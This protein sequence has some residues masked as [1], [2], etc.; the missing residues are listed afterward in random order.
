VNLLFQTSSE[1]S[2][3][4][5]LLA[6][7][8]IRGF[9]FMRYINPRLIL[10][11]ISLVMAAE[12]KAIIFYRLF[13]HFVSIDK[14]VRPAMGS[15]P[16]SASIGQKWRRFTNTPKFRGPSPRNLERKKR[17]IFDRFFVTSALD[18]AYLRNETSHRQTKC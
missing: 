11:L 2:S 15:Q 18:T 1:D 6:H 13:F 9:A 7:Q 3:F 16:N 17:Q 10:I 8:R 5:L 4:L 14:R 12:G